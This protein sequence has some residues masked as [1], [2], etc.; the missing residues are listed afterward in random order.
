MQTSFPPGEL[1]PPDII[2][3]LTN[4]VLTFAFRSSP[5]KGRNKEEGWNH[6]W[7]VTRRKLFELAL[8]DSKHELSPQRPGL[9]RMDSM[10]FLDDRDDGDGDVG[11]TMRLSTSLQNS[12]R[13]ELAMER[14]NSGEY[15]SIVSNR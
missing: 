2:D 4:Q 11:R 3:E 15:S 12:A 5:A 1:P 7:D 13:N 9:R 10:D 6:S 8:A 14:S